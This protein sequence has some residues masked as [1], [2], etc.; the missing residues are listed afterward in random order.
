MG[1]P[2]GGRWAV[3]VVLLRLLE[4][5][6]FGRRGV[7]GGH[8]GGLIPLVENHAFEAVL[9]VEVGSDIVGGGLGL[10]DKADPVTVGLN[11]LQLPHIVPVFESGLEAVDEAG[12]VSDGELSVSGVA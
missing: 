5:V 1:S 9:A 2:V 7:I 4:V 3:I 8:W 10:E 12:F 6:S 11:E